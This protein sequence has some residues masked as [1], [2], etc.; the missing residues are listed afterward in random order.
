MFLGGRRTLK[1][2]RWFQSAL[3]I[4]SRY[5]A[6]AP[7][8]FATFLLMAVASSLAAAQ[9]GS[10]SPYQDE[11]DGVSAGG[12]WM[13]FLSEDKMT[14]AKK[15]RFVLVSNNYFKEDPDSKPRVSIVCSDGKYQ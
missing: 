12:K 13:Q 7:A 9:Q 10:M 6:A 4:N 14:G 15:V 1:A 2:L 8:V 3:Q 5:A 11:K